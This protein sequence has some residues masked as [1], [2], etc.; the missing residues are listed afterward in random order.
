MVKLGRS[1]TYWLIFPDGSLAHVIAFAGIMT[2]APSV[3]ASETL[4]STGDIN[5][6]LC[7]KVVADRCLSSYLS[8]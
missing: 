8:Q 4:V 6:P 1:N 2:Y 5:T 3:T 7:Q